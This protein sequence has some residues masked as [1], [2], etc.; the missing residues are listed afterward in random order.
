M[1]N[2]K[3]IEALEEVIKR[4]VAEDYFMGP[5]ETIALIKRYIIELGDDKRLEKLNKEMGA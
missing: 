4:I 2:Q 3:K 5:T 1:S